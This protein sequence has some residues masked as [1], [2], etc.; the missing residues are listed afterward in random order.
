MKKI[1]LGLGLL[2]AAGNA[3]AAAYVHSTPAD[4]QLGSGDNNVEVATSVGDG[5]VQLQKLA[6]TLGAWSLAGTL[7]MGRINMLS[8]SGGDR[9]WIAGGGYTGGAVATTLTTQVIQLN[10]SGG[11]TSVTPAAPLLHGFYDVKVTRWGNRL[12]AGGGAIGAG[13]NSDKVYAADLAADGTPSNW[14]VVG[15]LP[16]LPGPTALTFDY[17]GRLAADYGKLVYVVSRP[18]AVYD[19][20]YVYSAVINPD[21]SLGTWSAEGNRSQANCL[22]NMAYSMGALFSLGGETTDYM[23]ESTVDRASFNSSGVLSSWSLSTA[24]PAPRSYNNGS[25]VAMAGRIYQVGGKTTGNP[26]LVTHPDVYSNVLSAGGVL[27]SWTTEASLPANSIFASVIG[28]KG[29]IFVI[30]GETGNIGT[31]VAT[32]YSASLN[33]GT[34]NAAQGIYVNRFDLGSD[35]AMSQLAYTIHPYK[36]GSVQVRTAP[37]GGSFGAWTAA[38]NDGTVDLGVTARYLEYRVVLN[39]V[40]G[41]TVQLERVVLH[42]LAAAPT[43]TAVPSL[44]TVHAN[45]TDFQ[46]GSGDGHVDINAGGVSLMKVAGSLGTWSH[47]GDAAF[48]ADSV[49]SWSVGDRLY[50]AGG[51]LM[52]AGGA[53]A[54][55]ST[56]RVAVLGAGGTLGPWKWV[57][58]LPFARFAAGLAR[59]GDYLYVGGG[60]DGVTSRTEIYRTRLDA[61][62][63]PGAWTNVGNLP[64]S[65][66]DTPNFTAA[67]GYLWYVQQAGNPGYDS[68]KCWAAAIN[69]DGSLGSWAAG[70]ARPQN[71]VAYSLQEAAGALYLV[72]GETISDG[73]VGTNKVSRALLDPLT[74]ALGAWSNLAQTLP[75]PR[76]YIS[77]PDN[78]YAGK[79]WQ[80]GGKTLASTPV[81]LFNTAYSNAFAAD[82]SLSSWATE[83]NLPFNRARGNVIGAGGY[84]WYLGGCTNGS[85]YYSSVSIYAASLNQGTANAAMGAYRHRFDQGSDQLAVSLAVTLASGTPASA[86]KARVRTAVNGGSWSAWSALSTPPLILNA[87][88]RWVEYE[89][90]F[91]DPGAGVNAGVTKVE[92]LGVPPTPTATPTM[93]LTAT[94]TATPPPGTPTPEL[95]SPPDEG[96]SRCFPNPA[97]GDKAHFAFEMHGPGT[98]RIR[99]WN[100]AGQLSSTVEDH[101]NQGKTLLHLTIKDYAPGVYLYQ[102]GLDYDDGR[103][104]T[105]PIK[106]FAVLP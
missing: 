60:S 17:E 104:V 101:F 6:G 64:G 97:H 92:L 75:N 40:S 89:L 81:N 9:I 86:V 54:V 8:W 72:G 30:G 70:P 52:P 10:A 80:V 11:I 63:L 84:L 103:K 65:Y 62:G 53:S 82:G 93:V 36:A 18:N 73:Y 7:D 35:Q 50:V 41:W 39:D 3:G 105:G 34:A 51:N 66:L 37:D 49:V 27:G 21:G 19:S 96:D 14:R 5:Y 43:P 85:N 20:N 79:L 33:Q 32:I 47:A 58:D 57:G 23:G 100:A 22:Y 12:F 91:T 24:L 4:F 95:P 1:I 99:V 55:T 74:R 83:A 90:V 59:W 48:P 69:P 71:L 2:A 25:E 67:G 68:N 26:T 98:G 102:L 29:K 16:T 45:G 61:S 94:P 76:S 78:D 44:P 42:T 87:T 31:E 88:V 28:L 46:R 38:T 106:R 15:S 77:T 13:A 56:I